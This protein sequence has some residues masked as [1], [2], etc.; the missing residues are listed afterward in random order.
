MELFYGAKE[1]FDGA[2][3]LAYPL[4]TAAFLSFYLAFYSA[5]FVWEKYKSPKG[6][7]ACDFD[8][9]SKLSAAVKMLGVLAFT[10]PLLGLLGTVSGMVEVFSGMNADSGGLM[11]GVARALITT[12]VGLCVAVFALTAKFLCV[13][14]AR[15]LKTKHFIEAK[16]KAGEG[17]GDE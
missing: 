2:G 6:G 8:S 5:I 11:R 14:F 9:F 1:Y 16:A 3:F 7:G 15:R 13:I 17:I 12:Q 10:A 4:L